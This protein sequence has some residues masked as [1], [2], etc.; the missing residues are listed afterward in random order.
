MNP[1][2]RYT[3]RVR[4]LMTKQW[5]DIVIVK[6]SDNFT[7][8]IADIHASLADAKTIWIEFKYLPAIARKRLGEATALQCVF[9]QDHFDVGIPSYVLIGTDHNKGHMLYRIDRYDGYAYRKD[10]L[11][12][13]ELMVAMQWTM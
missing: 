7:G 13:K 5:P 11:D 4:R 12:D 8:G 10:I 2:T 1:E 9:L 6:H 3:N